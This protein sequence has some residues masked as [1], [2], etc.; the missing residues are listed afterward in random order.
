MY[1]CEN[2]KKECINYY[3]S[4]R[5]CSSFCSRSYSR[6]QQDN[7]NYIKIGYCKF[8]KSEV[9]INKRHSLKNIIC[10]KCKENIKLNN[11]ICKICGQ[12]KCIQPEIC[13]KR[14]IFPSLIKYFDFDKMK[15]STIDV[16][17]EYER[18]R[19]LL[20]K[21]YWIDKLSIPLLVKKYNHNNIGNFFKIIKSL[22]IN[23]RNNSEAN[24]LL[25]LNSNI[26]VGSNKRYK[27]GWHID[28]QGNKH[29]YRSSY[30]LEYY[31]ILDKQ[32][33]SYE[34]EKLRLLYWD[35]KKML[36][37]ITIP[38]IYIKST[39]TIIEIKSAYTYD[40]INMNDKIKTYIKFGYNFK[41]ILDKKEFV[42]R[43]WPSGLGTRLL[44]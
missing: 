41:L 16:Y 28:W 30:E 27:Y 11:K 18:V 5:F 12:N 20:I 9:I 3:G 36:E 38:D 10:Y 42:L 44:I 43:S 37:R 7:N 39:N 40:E 35:S 23:T 4:G 8:C 24:S 34:T 6:K 22:N 13:K 29:F 32:K 1:I 14:Q 33:I 21:D 17:K 2:C 19:N 31:N 15:L 25:I 26:I